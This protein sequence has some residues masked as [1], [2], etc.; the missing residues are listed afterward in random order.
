MGLG[1]PAARAYH[2]IGCCDDTWDGCG[3]WLIFFGHSQKQ[4]NR[5]RGMKG[6]FKIA[7][8]CLAPWRFN[9]K[10]IFKSST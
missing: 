8:C 10:Q 2:D 4:K 1:P 6:C 9:P 7:G 3:D 5:S